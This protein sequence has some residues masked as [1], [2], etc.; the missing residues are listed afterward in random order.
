MTLVAAVESL[1]PMDSA[2]RLAIRRVVVL[3][4]PVPSP[5]AVRSTADWS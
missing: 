4:V 5:V 1:S 2:V 3:D